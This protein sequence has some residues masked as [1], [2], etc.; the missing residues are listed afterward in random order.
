M[1]LGQQ[2]GSS[3]LIREVSFLWS[4]L[5][6]EVPLYDCVSPVYRVMG[7]LL[8]AHLLITDPEQLF[9]DLV[10]KQYEGELL[11]MAHDLADRL[12]PAFQSSHTGLPLPRVSRLCT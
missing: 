8:S 5:Y 7:S 2:T 12:L 11:T 9:G 6:G 3:L 10:P 4:V 1:W